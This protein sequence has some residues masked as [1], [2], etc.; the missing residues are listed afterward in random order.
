MLTPDQLAAFLQQNPP[1]QIPKGAKQPDRV[2]TLFLMAWG[3]LFML[4]SIVYAGPGFPWRFYHEWQLDLGETATVVGRVGSVAKTFFSEGGSG[5]VTP[6]Y[7]YRTLF[8]VNGQSYVAVSYTTGRRQDVGDAVMVEHLTKR[9]AVAQVQGHR[10]T[11]SGLSGAFEL[12][13][14]AS[15]GLLL[16]FSG[17]H[18]RRR[19][20]QVLRDGVIVYGKL[21][22][23]TR[24][25]E[26]VINAP[27]RYREIVR[28]EGPDGTSRTTPYDGE[29]SMDK[30]RAGKQI[31]LLVDPA[32]PSR[33]VVLDSLLR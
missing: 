28:Y 4:L 12:L 20:F 33:V 6:V 15:V 8:E 25:K 10:L 18:P 16:L 3:V 14:P 22:I 2:L 26:H 11:P 1:R 9:P 5:S 29:F 24:T 13:V 7:Q 21:E 31:G 27:R 32:K 23:H 30:K 19:F 17:W